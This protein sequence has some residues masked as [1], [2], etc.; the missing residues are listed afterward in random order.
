MPNRRRRKKAE[1]IRDRK[2]IGELYLKGYSQMAIGERLNLSQQTISEDLKVLHQEW[3]ESAAQDIDEVRSA[4]LQKL[5]RVEIEYWGGWERSCQDEV[6]TTTKKVISDSETREETTVRVKP[7]AGDA[8]FI[9]GVKATVKQRCDLLGIEPPKTTKLEIGQELA[10]A[11]SALP[12]AFRGGI[13]S[14][15]TEDVDPGN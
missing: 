8:K 2:I 11:L 4:Q 12:E 10:R 3:L 6:I 13:I 5:D 14:D 15:L 1:I 7:Q 9:D